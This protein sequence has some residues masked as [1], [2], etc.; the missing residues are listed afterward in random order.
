MA[1]FVIFLL[2]LNAR[3][4]TEFSGQNY[5]RFRASTHLYQYGQTPKSL[6]LAVKNKKSDP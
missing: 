2:I 1:R 5:L 3:R 4:R 6:A